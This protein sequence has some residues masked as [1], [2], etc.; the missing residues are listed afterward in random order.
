MR[1]G[2][3]S[4]H[5]SGVRREAGKLAGGCYQAVLGGQCK[6]QASPGIAEKLILANNSLDPEAEAREAI[7]WVNSVLAN[8][9]HDPFVSEFFGNVEQLP[10][11]KGQKAEPA[12]FRKG[13]GVLDDNL[14]RIQ[15]KKLPLV[16]RPDDV[17]LGWK[18]E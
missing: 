4:A 9:D 17:I 1:D 11:P 8:V 14:V 7:Q 6:L 12:V 16:S 10:R 3:G 5:R 13:K 18:Y 2:G 15:R